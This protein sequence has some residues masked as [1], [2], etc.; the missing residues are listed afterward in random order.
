MRGYNGD[1]QFEVRGLLREASYFEGF[2]SLELSMDADYLMF[3]F[4]FERYLAI[5]QFKRIELPDATELELSK[6]VLGIIK[7]VRE[8]L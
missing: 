2:K 4:V 8:K 1:A 6:Y 7:G 5:V 3:R